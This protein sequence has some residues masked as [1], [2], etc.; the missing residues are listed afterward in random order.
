[1]NI[2]DEACG[3]HPSPVFPLNTSII[4]GGCRILFHCS[5]RL[6]QAGSPSQEFPLISSSNHLIPPASFIIPF[7]DPW[8]AFG[9]LL[10]D[11]QVVALETGPAAIKQKWVI[12]TSDVFADQRQSSLALGLLI[13]TEH[14]FLVGAVIQQPLDLSVSIVRL[15]LGLE[16]GA[17]SAELSSFPRALDTAPIFYS[18]RYFSAQILPRALCVLIDLDSLAATLQIF[19]WLRVQPEKLTRELKT[20]MEGRGKKPSNNDPQEMNP[21]QT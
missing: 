17:L 10:P 7:N 1:M 20:L 9:S 15:G 14:T 4:W 2:F 6:H 18:P 5:P 12:K 3:I 21:N 16:P 8:Q 13:S 11:N 19:V